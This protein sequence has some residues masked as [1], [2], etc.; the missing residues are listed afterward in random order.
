[1]KLRH[2]ALTVSLVVCSGL[3][4]AAYAQKSGGHLFSGKSGKSKPKVNSAQ[5]I[6]AR[7]NW[8]Y[9]QRAYPLQHIPAFARERAWNDF[10]RMQSQQRQYFLQKYGAD[11]QKQMAALSATTLAPIVT[12]PWQP[13]G[14]QPTRAFFNQPDVSGRVS[15]LVVDPCDTTGQ[16]VFLGGAQGGLWKSTDGGL[17]WTTVG[18]QAAIPS[19]AVGSLA[20]PPASPSACLASPA[21]SKTIYVGTGEGNLSYDSY[22]GAG[23]LACTTAD[24]V[25]YTCTPDQ[26]LG[27]FNTTNPLNQDYG[28]PFIGSLAVNPQNPSI[29]L[30]AVRGS[31]S[32]LPSGIYCSANAGSTWS[33]VLPGAG[34]TGA[35]GTDVAFDQAGYGYAAIG[36]IYGSTINGVYKSAAALGNCKTTLNILMGLENT[37][38]SASAMGRISF[39]IYSTSTTSSSGDEIFAA[40]ANSSD[41]SGTLLGVFGSVDGGGTWTQMT[42][43]NGFTTTSGG[44]CNDQCFYD[45]AIT[46]DPHNPAVVYAGGSAP[47]SG[48]N[49]EG[50]TI[51][52]DTNAVTVSGST[53]TI[54]ASSTW[55]DVSLNDPSYCT[56]SNSTGCLFGVHV[57]AHAIAFAP[58]GA[59]G[60]ASRVYVGTDGGVWGSASGVNPENF[61]SYGWTDLNST[62]GLTQIYS[63]MSNN[64]SGWQF[65]TFLGSQDNG[66]QVYG[67]ETQP[68][69]WDDTLSCGDGGITLVDPLIPSTVYG[70]CAYIPGTSTTPAFFGIEKSLF[71]GNVDD[72]ND[73]STFYEASSG[74]NG[75]DAG[76]FIPPFAIDPNPTG[77]TGDAQTLYFGT[78]RVYQT[79][80]G[81]NSWNVI[82]PDVTGADPTTD[83]NTAVTNFCANNPGYCVLTALA[84]A[85]ANS[86]EVV[87]GSSV[88]HIAVTVNAGQG[89]SSTWTDVTG[90][91]VLPD[92]EITQVAVDPKNK[93]TLY[94]TFSGFSSCSG[95]DGKGHVY[96]GALTPTGTP[97]VAWTD[98]SSA[99]LPCPTGSGNLPDIPVN[100][101]AIDP[102]LADTLYVGT[103]VGVYMGTLQG[104]APAYTGACWQ[105]L[106]TGLPNS[107]VLSL[108]LN[109]AS[110]T[111]IAGTHGRSAWTLPLGGLPAFG[112]SSLSPASTGAGAAV[113]TMTLGGNNFTANSVVH[114]GS[115]TTLTQTSPPSGCALPACIAVSVPTSLTSSSG[116]VQISVTDPSETSP[117]NS[118]TFTVT[119]EVPTVTNISP[120]SSTAQN[121]LNLTLQGTHFLT[122]TTIGLATVVSP[123]PCSPLAQPSTGTSTKIAASISASCLQYG[124]IYFVTANNP[125]PGGGSSN[126][127]QIAALAPYGN[128]CTGMST[129]GCL[130]TVTGAPPANGS[131]AS[132]QSITTNNFTTTEDTSGAADGSGPS[133]ASCTTVNPNGISNDSGD[134]KSVW[135][136]YT[137]TANTTAEVKTIGSN[138]DT[139]LSVWTGTS[140]SLNPVACNDDIVTGTDLPSQITNL[141]LTAN[142]TYYFLVS[143]WG[144]PVYDGSGNLAE[145]L[146]SGGKL[147][148]NMTTAPS[149][150]FTAS[151]SGLSPS[152]VTAGSSASFTLTL[153]G[154]SSSPSGTV[155]LQPCT[156]SPSTTTITC[157]YSPGSLSVG[158]SSSSSS[159]VTISTVARSAIP[160][161]GPFQSPPLGWLVAVLAAASMLA[162]LLRGAMARGRAVTIR[163]RLAAALGFA[164]LAGVLLF[165]GACGGGGG[166]GGIPAPPGTTAGTYTI[167]VPTSP[168]PGGSNASV[169]LTVQ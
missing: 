168:S 75:S 151:A 86:N 23:V 24:G 156:T 116:I 77:S 67:Q 7:A 32:T 142:T 107:A 148:F 126:P 46:I 136:Q 96:T 98:I 10:H 82:S 140:S 112:L 72:T 73:N 160:P 155:T 70:E 76:N 45:L 91:G 165:S 69:T 152:T 137:P 41:V 85:P 125:L 169:T 28:G 68:A 53:A 167:T 40:I 33:E 18:N 95:C 79:T 43:P 130:L 157:S 89:A 93:S 99:A 21:T 22:Y 16:T 135:F 149:P 138:Y 154:S 4:I 127:Y 31:G 84:V 66:T 134:Y 128:S 35:Y 57:D 121:P 14:P 29:L 100:S 59:S 61:T 102:D 117:T 80:N 39:S 17:H 34:T 30:A 111:L 60:A 101:I 150:T 1:M 129:P 54:N 123:L 139:I 103:D 114:W 63:G 37:A 62:L 118:L 163:S 119:S 87:T 106:G 51:I 52:A 42:D 159:T 44:F 113:F 78:Y 13:I 36:N 97:A 27:A 9:R 124:G 104:T 94:A 2:G 90:S 147:V 109:D 6:R 56:N 55:T 143:D 144:V 64:P 65:R 146:P 81:G 166:G 8:F 38:G 105:P 115:S 164:L 108:S 158:P 15:A 161:A 49:G 145:V 20:T 132:A 47:G 92:R 83:S 58:P 74:I 141:G 12:N 5:L 122:S 110:R 162:F 131:F 11:Y 71:N 3:V 48:A 25:N 19:L 133:L 120:I 50:N 88:G 153:A 26:T